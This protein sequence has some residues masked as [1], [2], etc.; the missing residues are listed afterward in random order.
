[1]IAQICEYARRGCEQRR[2]ETTTRKATHLDAYGAS[3]EVHAWQALSA[4]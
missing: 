1:M 4:S 2:V 3:I